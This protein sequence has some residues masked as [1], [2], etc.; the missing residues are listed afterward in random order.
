MNVD[1]YAVTELACSPSVLRRCRAAI[2][3]DCPADVVVALS[4]DDEA[5]VRACV[6]ARSDL[7]PAVAEAL[8]CDRSL[9]VLR[10][11][12]ANDTLAAHVRAAAALVR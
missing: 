9:L 1:P 6:A 7:P 4:T 5:E 3:P 8:A 2:H 12:A 10:S 11:V